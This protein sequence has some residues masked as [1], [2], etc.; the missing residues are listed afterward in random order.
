MLRSKR[1]SGHASQTAVLLLTYSGLTDRGEHLAYDAA[2]MRERKHEF[3]ALPD[4]IQVISA[5]DTPWKS[6]TSFSSG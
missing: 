4:T 1:R 5:A 3:N 2:G 6:C